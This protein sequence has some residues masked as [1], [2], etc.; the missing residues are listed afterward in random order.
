MHILLIFR[1]IHHSKHVIFFSYKKE[2]D[3]ICFVQSTKK[4][5]TKQYEQNYSLK[6]KPI[7]SLI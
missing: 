2:L 1:D 5:I 7:D 3:C 6:K 4:K